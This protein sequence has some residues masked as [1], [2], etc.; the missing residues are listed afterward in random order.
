MRR[1]FLF[2]AFLTMQLY[3]VETHSNFCNSSSYDNYPLFEIVFS[4]TPSDLIVTDEGISVNYNGELFDVQSLERVGDNWVVRVGSTCRRGHP[5]ICWYC[6][7]CAVGG[8]PYRCP[9]DCQPY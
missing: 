3:A 8:C 2:L 4:V 7:G 6:R 5:M 9:G 1:Y